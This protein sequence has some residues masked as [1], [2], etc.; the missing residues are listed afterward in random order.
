[1]VIRPTL[2]TETSRLKNKFKHEENSSNAT[3][4]KTIRCR[5][6][7]DGGSDIQGRNRKQLDT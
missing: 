1:M 3:G 2:Q 7:W 6:E 4:N 5:R